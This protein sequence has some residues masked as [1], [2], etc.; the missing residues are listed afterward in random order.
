M[1]LSKEE[2]KTYD[3]GY[4]LSRRAKG[5]DISDFEHTLIEEVLKEREE[6]Q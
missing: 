2:Y 4:I 5:E 1:A 6:Y 3:S